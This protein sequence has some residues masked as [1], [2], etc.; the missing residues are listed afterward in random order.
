MRA[1]VKLSHSQA[2]L[3]SCGN[4]KDKSASIISWEFLL[5]QGF[6]MRSPFPCH[7]HPLLELHQP[8]RP[9][10]LLTLL[11]SLLDLGQPKSRPFLQ[12]WNSPFSISSIS[13]IS[14]GSYQQIISGP[15]FSW[16]K[17]PRMEKNF[18]LSLLPIF[19]HTW[20]SVLLCLSLTQYPRSKRYCSCLS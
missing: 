11:R 6:S 8:G 13:S 18:A 17:R 10:L 9:H 2:K 3:L 15:K 14:T 5:L 20:S 7:P 16:P 4:T 19:M 12:I 1:S